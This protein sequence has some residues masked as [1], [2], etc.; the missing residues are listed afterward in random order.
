M[1]RHERILGFALTV[2]VLGC[3]PPTLNALPPSEQRALGEAAVARVCGFNLDVE[4]PIT[5]D[6][7]SDL[8]LA[9]QY[10]DEIIPADL[11]PGELSQFFTQETIGACAAD[12]EW[13]GV[14]YDVQ[15][16][17]RRLG[18][19]AEVRALLAQSYSPERECRFNGEAESATF[20]S[21]CRTLGFSE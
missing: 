14:N 20:A 7:R 6:H 13:G 17:V 9:R 4:T 1:S 5:F 10:L 3:T 12:L 18:T 21:A 11:G 19:D 2:S 16:L 15:R 8:S